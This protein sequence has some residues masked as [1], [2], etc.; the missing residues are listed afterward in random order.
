MRNFELEVITNIISDEIT[1][2]VILKNAKIK[3]IFNLDDV[4]LE[5]YL[6]K[7]TG[8]PIMKYSQVFY[9]NNF[10]KVNKPYED[11]KQLIFDRSIPVLGFASKSKKYK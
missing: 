1:E 4:R 3:K 7:T 10:Y 2:R 9:E 6:N 5:Q 11:L 8:K